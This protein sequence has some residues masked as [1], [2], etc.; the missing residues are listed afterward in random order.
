MEN[1]KNNSKLCCY[2]YG[3]T[4]LICFVGGTFLLSSAVFSSCSGA[5]CSCCGCLG[6][7]GLPLIALGFVVRV[8]TGRCCG[9]SSSCC[10]KPK[11]DS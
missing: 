5:A 8:W 6:V 7:L 11:S 4:D 3:L 2:L 1:E 9:S 10:S